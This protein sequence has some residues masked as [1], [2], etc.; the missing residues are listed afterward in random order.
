MVTMKKISLIFLLITAMILFVSCNNNSREANRSINNL[1][2]VTETVDV[3]NNNVVADNINELATNA[4]NTSVASEILN[5][6]ENI[7]EI[8]SDCGFFLLRARE[9]FG[10]LSKGEYIIIL[11]YF[12]SRRN[13]EGSFNIFVQVETIDGAIRGFVNERYITFLDDMTHNFWCTNILLTREYYYQ[14]S[15]EYIFERESWSLMEMK[16]FFHEN[17]LFISERHLLVNIRDFSEMFR[18]ISMERNEN[19]YTFLAINTGGDE[20]EIILLDDGDGI[21]IT[22]FTSQ[23]YRLDRLIANAMNVRFIPHDIE[24][25]IILRENIVEWVDEQLMLR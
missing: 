7:A 13:E 12:Y 18:F 2:G 15:V 19:T 1:S 14:E 23:D 22:Q 16:L 6:A 21:F 17:D 10:R 25:S 8:N 5:Y 9:P 11:D 3:L 4:N 20:V 24:K